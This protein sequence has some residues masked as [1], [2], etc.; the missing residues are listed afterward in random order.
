MAPASSL[1]R[2]TIVLFMPSTATVMRCPS[3]ITIPLIMIMSARRF[4]MP[5]TSMPTRHREVPCDQ[6]PLP[7]MAR[8]VRGRDGRPA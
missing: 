4:L 2:P 8:S 3:A 5:L 7:L 1:Q 6:S